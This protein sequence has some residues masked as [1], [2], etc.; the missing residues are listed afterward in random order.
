MFVC[1]D[2]I[3]QVRLPEVG[4]FY[5]Q[6]RTRSLWNCSRS[7]T[8]AAL[9][10][11]TSRG[12]HLSR[13]LRTCYF[14]SFIYP[15]RFLSNLEQTAGMRGIDKR[16]NWGQGIGIHLCGLL[17]GVCEERV[18][19]GTWLVNGT[20]EWRS[21]WTCGEGAD[22]RKV[23]RLLTK[24]H[25]S[26]LQDWNNN[27]SYRPWLCVRKPQQ[28]QPRG[29]TA[30]DKIFHVRLDSLDYITETEHEIADDQKLKAGKPEHSTVCV[31]EG[32]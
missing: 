20:G 19:G 31:C 3:W 12:R 22:E 28:H 10:I 17:E 27:Y 13:I 14:P 23:L 5:T 21:M 26:R 15:P 1:A 9:C 25:L 7:L 18:G 2:D 6:T 29:H 16:S 4:A 8:L 24:N 32:F 30:P 11:E